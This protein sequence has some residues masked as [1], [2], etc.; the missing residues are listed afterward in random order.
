MRAYKRCAT[1]CAL[2]GIQVI[3][4]YT[5]N[6]MTTRYIANHFKRKGYYIA[7]CLNTGGK[8]IVKAGHETN[9][10]T[11]TPPLTSIISVINP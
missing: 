4:P 11:V 7:L 10:L 1:R 3:N 2:R 8:V 9:C 5:K 6:E